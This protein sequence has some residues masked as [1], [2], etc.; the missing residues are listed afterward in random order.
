MAIRGKLAVVCGGAS[1]IGRAMALDLVN[2]GAK[3]VVMDIDLASMQAMQKKSPTLIYYTLDVTDL[4]AVQSVFMQVEK[5]HGP[6]F[7]LVHTAAIMPA[8]T[9]R[10][11]SIEQT[12][13]VMTVNYE[14]M[15]HV[16]QTV[17]PFLLSRNEG[18][19]VVMGSVAGVL[20]LARFGAYGASKAATN[21]YME[22]LQAEHA[23]SQVQLL[24]VCPAAVDT[25]LIDQ[26]IEHGPWF[27]RKQKNGFRIASTKQI[28]KAIERGL[29][30]KKSK[31]YP[32]DAW[33]IQFLY[34]LFPSLSL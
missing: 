30:T 5:E 17:L 6:I 32:G 29:Q 13:N 34:R 8:A 15:V 11:M 26:A 19:I 20:P 27:L 14:G 33:L 28:I 4:K 12:I 18:Q 1:G 24:L 21:F 2:Q 23:G 3:V 10:Q 31:I 22:V 25:P 9:F 16:T 7:R